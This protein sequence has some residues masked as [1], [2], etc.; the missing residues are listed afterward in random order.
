[1]HAER[2]IT[3]AD[4]SARRWLPGVELGNQELFQGVD[5]EALEPFLRDCRVESLPAG[6]VLIEIG[7]ANKQLYLLL[8][9]SL[10]VHLG[11]PEEPALLHAH[12]GETVGELS[13]IDGRSCSAHVVA[14][15]PC[16]VLVLDEELVWLLVNTFHAVSTN[17]LFT[18]AR[19]LR[20]GNNLIS[21]D[22][23]QIRRYQFQTTIDGLTELFNRYW[24]D[25]M[26]PR[27][28]ERSRR[29]GQPLCVLMF[30]IDYFKRV[31][32]EFGHPAG[33]DVIRQ[34]ARCLRNHVRALD[35]PARYGGE[36]FALICPSTTLEAASC[37]GLPV[38]HI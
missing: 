35:L 27:Q 1:M 19:R 21:E 7:H 11:S 17:L 24:L 26:L 32:D 36:E 23:Q 29:S 33:D 22:R 4:P 2:T 12:P 10:G 3:Y 16:R 31:N 25:K 15:T 28:M 8:E 30:D 14:A 13:L 5:P 34:V 37:L 18:L 20:H 6:D 9:G 38:T